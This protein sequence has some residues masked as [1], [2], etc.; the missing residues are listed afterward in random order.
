MRIP[1]KSPLKDIRINR[2]MNLEKFKTLLSEEYLWF[3]KLNNFSDEHEGRALVDWEKS[4]IEITDRWR[5]NF[6]ANCWNCDNDENFALWNIYL[7]KNVDGICVVSSTESFKKSIIDEKEIEGYYVNYFR[8]GIVLNS[9]SSFGLAIS[10]YDWYSYENELRFLKY[11]KDENQ[12][13]GIKVKIKPKTLIKELIL[14]PNINKD[15]V[16]EVIKLCAVHNINK[17]LVKNS[18][19]KDKI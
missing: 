9:I 6:V 4:R 16:D 11:L 7:N 1:I 17:E 14:S 10:K 3:N 2:Y 19:I 12:D 8:H 13:K 15:S 18:I 5:E